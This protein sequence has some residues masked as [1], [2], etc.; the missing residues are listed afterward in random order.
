MYDLTVTIPT[1]NEEANIKKIVMAVDAVFCKN[2]LI[3]P[4][5]GINF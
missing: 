4:T 5:F 3:D 1:F 2:A